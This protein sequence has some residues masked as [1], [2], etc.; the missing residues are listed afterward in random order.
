MHATDAYPLAVSGHSSALFCFVATGISSQRFFN[1]VDHVSVPVEAE[2][3]WRQKRQGVAV[4]TKTFRR[5]I[6]DQPELQLSLKAFNSPWRIV[7]CLRI[8]A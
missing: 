5:G 3:F 7:C 6:A 2:N 4:A 1:V 8:P